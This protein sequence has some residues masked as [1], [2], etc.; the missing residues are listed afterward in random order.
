MT[1]FEKLKNTINASEST[2]VELQ[3]LL[4][5]VPAIAPES[6][7]DGELKKCIVLEEYLKKLGFSNFQRLDAPDSR[8]S[9][10]LRPNLIVT[11]PGKYYKTENDSVVWIMAH[12]D[13]V[14]PGE[15]KSWNSDPWKVVYDK[16]SGK[17]I[18]RGVEDNQQGLTAGVLAAYSLIKN[19]IIPER[20]VKLL[21]MADEEFG[22]TY[23]IKFL[24][25]NHKS[26]FSNKDIILIPDGGDPK[27]ETIEIAEKN[28]LWLKVLTKGQQSHGSMPHKGVNAHLAACKL[29]LSLNDLENF[30]AKQDDLFDPPYSTFQPTKK[31]NNVQTVNIIPGEDIFY[32][33]C[34]IL[35][36]YTLEEVRK[37]LNIRCKKIETEFNVKIELEEL[38]AEQSPA[39]SPNSEVVKL[40][41]QAI[42]D[43]HNIESKTIG[44]G[45]GTVGAC[46]RNEGFEAAIWS[47]MDEVCHQPNEYC[48]IKNIIKDATTLACLF[49]IK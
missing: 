1:N 4:T 45:G 10:G 40:L 9:S 11:I 15:L 19:N 43:S 26:I 34:R 32:M 16:E 30:F 17:L 29:A 7:G 23:G 22:S 33:D 35:P 42:K 44:I 2:I 8:V 3:T 13:V 28:I 27:G 6:G 47:T 46:L 41:L 38:Q 12:L 36:C 5:S 39:T 48:Y 20:T 18:G 31:E 21:F 24:L 37:E 14:P 49:L 25:K